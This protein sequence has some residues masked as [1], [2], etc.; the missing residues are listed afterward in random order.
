MKKRENFRLRYYSKGRQL[1]TTFA[2][3]HTIIVI[4]SL[5]NFGT[6]PKVTFTEWHK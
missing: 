5:Q 2:Y 6:A 3:V 1:G 4:L